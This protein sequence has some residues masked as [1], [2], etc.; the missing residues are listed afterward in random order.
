MNE[1]VLLKPKKILVAYFSHSG[2]TREIA[3]QIKTV[4]GGDILRAY[5]SSSIRQHIR[6]WWTRPR[7]KSTLITTVGAR[8]PEALEKMTGR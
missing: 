6:L 1:T 7:K 4:T 5:R 3:N 2:N 8:Y